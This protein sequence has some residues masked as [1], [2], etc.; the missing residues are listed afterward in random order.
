MAELSPDASTL[1]AGWTLSSSHLTEKPSASDFYKEW[2]AELYNGTTSTQCMPE[3]DADFQD[4]TGASLLKLHT[5]AYGPAF[6]LGDGVGLTGACALPGETLPLW[7]NALDSFNVPLD[8]IKKI[9]LHVQGLDRPK[10]KLHPSTPTV[11]TVTKTL[12]PQLN[13]WNFSGMATSVADIYN[14]KIEFWGK[15]GGFIV[16]KTDDFHL[17]NFLK[18]DVWSFATQAGIDNPTLDSFTQYFDFIDGPQG[19]LRIA[20]SGEAAVKSAEWRSAVRTEHEAAEA[21]RDQAR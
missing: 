4:G 6:D 21:R 10:A 19:A 8:S 3:V 9:V 17:D 12:D 16:G 1:A 5:Y 13:W 15:S 7:S 20:Y 18:G 14:V 11:G 2:F